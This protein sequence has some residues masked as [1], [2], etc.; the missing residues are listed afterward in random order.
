MTMSRGPLGATAGAGLPAYRG[1]PYTRPVNFGVTFTGAPGESHEIWVPKNAFF[2]LV[3][4][5][6][7]GTA[8]A[9]YQVADT[10]PVGVIGYVGLDGV[11]FSVFP[12]PGT[13]AGI[14]SNNYTNARLILV[15][16]VGVAS[17]V[18]GS[19]YGWEVTQDGGYRTG[20]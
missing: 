7:K 2:E 4:M 17:V 20:S 15:D 18:H 5:I 3:T 6:I 14:R 9:E 12:G 13:L 19:C 10:T 1:L 8:A 16:P 11:N